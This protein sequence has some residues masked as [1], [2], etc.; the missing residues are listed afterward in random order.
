VTSAQAQTNGQLT[1]TV[2]DDTGAALVGATI[3]ARG[4]SAGVATSDGAGRFTIRGLSDG[5]YALTASLTGFVPLRRTVRVVDGGAETLTIT[6]TVGAFE[7]TVVTAAR[8]GKRDLE[9]LPMAV[10]ALPGDEIA[11]LGARSVADLAGLAPSVTFSQNSDFAQL[12]IRGIGTNVVFAGSDPSSPVYVDG[13]YLARPV[14]VVGDFLDLDRVEVLRGPQGTLYGRNAVG[15][16]LN[17]ITKEPTN[18]LEVSGRV[19]AGNLD[20]LR[21]EAHVSGPVVR[22]RIL[23]SGAFVRSASQGY[24]N[25]LDHPDHPLGGDDVNAARGKLQFLLGPR[26]SLLVSGDVTDQDPVPLSYSKVLAVKPGFQIDN[27][28]GLRNV[29][30]STPATSRQLQFGTAARLTMELTPATTLTSLTAFR[31]LEYDL[32][33]D[34]DI[35]EL[36]LTI[37]RVRERQHQISEEVTLSSRHGSV[38]WLGGIFLFDEADRQP[39]AVEFGAQ[40]VQNFLNPSVSSTSAAG[41]G[42][43]TV[44]LSRRLALTGGLRY[45]REQKTIDNSGEVVTL[46]PPAVTVPGSAYAYTDSIDHTAWTPKASVEFRAADRTLAYVSATRGFK[47]GGFNLT[48]REPGR[49]FAPE[50]A[51]SYEGGLKTT[52]RGGRARMNIAAFHTDYTNL[53][54]QTAIRP[55]VI[56]ISNAASA[57]I[58]GVEVEGGS[59]LTRSI[60]AGGH[61]AWLRAR[62]DQYTAV[63]VGGVTG[64]VAGNQL[65]N[66]PDWSGRIWIDWTRR[67]RESTLTVRADSR[68]Q[69]T[70]YF[71]PFND[72]I[73]RQ[74][75]Y[76]LLDISAELALNQQWTL[77]VFSRNITNTDFITGT[78]S[79]PPPAIGGRPGISRQV[80][81]QLAVRR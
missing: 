81:V 27:P 73:Q 5:T 11:A 15:G 26:S 19:A 74:T 68:W 65:N 71:T 3:L 14:S 29:R 52:T 55:G 78:F 64:D 44:N 72:A 50:W 20:T 69:S 43:A 7:E 62:Y 41:F 48:S 77:G 4:P 59:E 8:T 13:V 23:A 61:I 66:A 79:S 49:G 37:S 25:D 53:Q 42:Q 10:S 22:D 33:T 70:V 30:T 16:A 54:V 35:T 51:W 58:Q 75:P 32:T 60:R 47:S 31:R 1:G 28:A 38:N 9:T 39:T 2:I 18:D 12:T 46:A 24:V 21:A 76:G 63:G 17:V 6:L 45:T 67:F 57:T 36:N 40:G 56:D 80:G 34:A